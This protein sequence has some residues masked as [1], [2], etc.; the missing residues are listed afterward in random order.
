MEPY[1]TKLQ[2]QIASHYQLSLKTDT[3][4]SVEVVSV[5]FQ[6]CYGFLKKYLKQG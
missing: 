5:K 1:S 6:I 4:F 2:Q 3:W